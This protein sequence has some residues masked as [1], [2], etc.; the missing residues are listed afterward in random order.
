M[1]WSGLGRQARLTTDGAR[2]GLLYLGALG[3]NSSGETQ[4]NTVI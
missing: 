1:L 3:Y 4:A 2:P